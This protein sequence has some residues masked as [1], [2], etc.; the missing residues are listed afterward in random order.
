MAA[1]RRHVD[2]GGRD[3]VNVGIF[4]ESFSQ[5][6]T[7]GWRWGRARGKWRE[8]VTVKLRRWDENRVRF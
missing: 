1:M 3:G 2:G 5:G 6:E 8:R 4:G 7:E